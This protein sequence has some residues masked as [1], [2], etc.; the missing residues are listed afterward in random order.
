[1][2]LPEVSPDRR[3]AATAIV[4]AY[5]LIEA[6]LWT[7]A[8]VQL[9]WSAAAACWIVWATV[10]QKRTARELGIGSAGFAASIWVALV[11]AAIAGVIV[12]AGAA[13]GTLHGLSGWN[14]VPSRTVAYVIWALEQQFILQ[15]F[16]YL[17]LEELA[18]D[19]LRSALAATALFTAAHIPNLF[20]LL[21]TFIFG[22][23]ST[24]LFRRYRNIYP[25][26]IAHA[27]LG[28]ALAVSVPDSVHRHMRVGLGYLHYHADVAPTP[29]GQPPK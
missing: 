6:A 14:R 13:A 5:V 21:A 24:Q 9:A 12:A 11:A 22:I 26:A 17:N 29:I 2:W 4:V 18:G 8:R 20:L 28:L 7:R 27:L 15:S 3:F 1:L 10:R 19:R 23:C 25:L 16:F